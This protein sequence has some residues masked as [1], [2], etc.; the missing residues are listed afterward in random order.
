MSK[1]TRKALKTP[2]TK[3]FTCP[4]CG[5]NYCAVQS[6]VCGGC[7]SGRKKGTQGLRSAHANACAAKV[8]NEKHKRK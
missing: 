4:E 1:K 7:S 8:Y 5:N 2:V 6:G 3:K